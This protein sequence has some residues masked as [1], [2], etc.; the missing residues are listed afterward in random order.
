LKVDHSFVQRMSKNAED[1]IIV[2]STITLA[3]N[4]GLPVVAEGVEDSAT[5]LQLQNYG[6]DFAQGYGIAIPMS[7]SDAH[8]WLKERM[9]APVPL[10]AVV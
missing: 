8:A 4:L 3:H 5:L 10:R 6:C 7:E 1:A 2:Q 9:G